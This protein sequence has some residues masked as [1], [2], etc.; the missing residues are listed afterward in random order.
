MYTREN[1]IADY[2][3]LI[4][5]LVDQNIWGYMYTCVC[6]YINKICADMFPSIRCGFIL[7]TGSISVRKSVINVKP[8]H[9]CKH[10]ALPIVNMSQWN[11]LM[12]YLSH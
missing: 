11:I 8:L 3:N 9:C 4:L 1:S 6:L 5:C 12:I 7:A 2:L 10:V